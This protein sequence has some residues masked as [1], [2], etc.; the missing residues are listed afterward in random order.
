MLATPSDSEKWAPVVADRNA[1]GQRT[2]LLV[3]E[4]ADDTAA[5]R[6]ATMAEE[7][8]RGAPFELV[9]TRGGV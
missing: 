7:I 4:A 5:E 6:A 3:A 9:E 1:A 2:A 8:F